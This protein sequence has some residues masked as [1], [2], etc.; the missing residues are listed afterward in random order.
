MHRFSTNTNFPFRATDS[1]CTFQPACECG[2]QTRVA[3]PAGCGLFLSDSAVLRRGLRVSL[4][5]R[6]EKRLR[7]RLLPGPGALAAPIHAEPSREKSRP[8]RTQP[9]LPPATE[10]SSL[11]FFQVLIQLLAKPNL[12]SFTKCASAKQRMEIR[13]AA[14]G[15]AAAGWFVLLAVLLPVCCRVA[16]ERL[17]YTILEEM[18]RGSLVGPLARDLGLSPAELPARKLRIVSGNIEQYFIRG[19]GN[20][21]PQVKKRI[22]REGI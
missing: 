1:I 17:P 8:C 5:A 16:P 18:G 3:G 4:L 22:D 10:I 12:K 2:L 21:N 20:K 14:Q 6:A 11:Y 15:Q 7:H 19:E 13:V 9:V